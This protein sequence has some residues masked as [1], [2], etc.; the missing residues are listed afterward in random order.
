MKSIR[1]VI[2]KII[3]ENA[4]QSQ[5][6]KIAALL[7]TKDPASITQGMELAKS[8]GYVKF[9]SYSGPSK[10]HWQWQGKDVFSHQ[11]G[12]DGVD[13]GLSDAIEK[14]WKAG[15]ANRIEGGNHKMWSTRS[16]D[17]FIGW[18]I[19]LNGQPS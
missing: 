17:G 7:C 12:I 19:R 4:A 10:S 14:E 5:Y 15:K 8:M 16:L 3:L 2:R 9:G 11:W 1:Q 6:E 13:E 18:E